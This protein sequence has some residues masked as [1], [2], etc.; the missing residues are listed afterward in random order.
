VPPVFGTMTA[1][2]NVGDLTEGGVTLMGGVNCMSGGSIKIANNVSR[3]PVVGPLGS[4]AI[5]VGELMVSGSVDTYL[6]D[7]SIM[8]KG[9]ANTLTS[10]TTF[11]GNAAGDK[12]GYRFD[13]P[14]I[15]IT[16][17][18]AVPGK[19]QARKVSGPFEAEPHPT[20]GYTMSIGRF[21]LTP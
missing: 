14:A 18:S 20:L 5:N 10:F 16:P 4:A 21:W 1:T 19:N 11:N 8:A 13:V 17:D 2:S 7:A 6:A 15:R 9:I 12:E 3:E